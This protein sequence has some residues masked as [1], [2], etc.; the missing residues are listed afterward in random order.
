M[1][2]FQGS[3]LELRVGYE[4]S[5]GVAPT[6]GYLIGAESFD[7]TV[8]R[9]TAARVLMDGSFVQGEESTGARTA[10]GTLTIPLQ[11][12]ALGVFLYARYGAPVTTGASPYTH[13]FS[14]SATSGA[15]MIIE[16]KNAAGEYTQ[17]KGV[18]IN[19]ISITTDAG[20]ATQNATINYT[21][22]D[23]LEATSSFLTG[24]ETDLTGVTN[25]GS[26]LESFHGT[27]SSGSTLSILNFTVNE[28]RALSYRNILNGSANAAVAFEGKHTPT[29]SV[30]VL[31]ETTNTKAVL[32]K[33]RARTSD[34][35]TL[36]LQKDANE[37]FKYVF[38]TIQW[39]ESA[40]SGSGDSVER[41]I[42]L[43][44]TADTS[45]TAVLIN[46]QSS[47]PI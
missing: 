45:F 22:Q 19:S 41:E 17:A 27:Y 20:S 32:D 24:S 3:D 18:K 13:T 46:A 43:D 31:G 33:A 42:T 11:S 8:T 1:A 25:G 23:T 28:E 26:Y 12:K 36:T 35:I 30:T 44:F 15:S 16:M 9:E 5:F 10:S 38:P 6:D 39:N 4:T 40:S 2:Y 29:G 21:A 47:Y 14:P 34:N 7:P 37:S